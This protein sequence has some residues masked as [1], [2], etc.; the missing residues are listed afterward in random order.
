MAAAEELVEHLVLVGCQHQLV[1]RQTH[2]PGDMAGADIAEIARRHGEADP[3]VVAASGAE[4]ACEIVDDLRQQ[5]RPVDRIDGADVVS[6]LEVEVVRDRLDDILAI[7]EDAFD[8]DVVDIR[9][10]QAEHLRL[11]ERAHA[12]VRAEHEDIDAAFAAHRIFGGAAG[13]ARGRAEDIQCL[14]AAP[15]FVFEQVAQQLHRHVLEGQRRAVRQRLAGTA[16]RLAA[17]DASAA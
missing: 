12:T 11:L 17:S 5:P 4:I 14:A 13:I 9:I 2:H 7:V 8:R 3:L 16:R 1:D 15:Q 6:A 10:L